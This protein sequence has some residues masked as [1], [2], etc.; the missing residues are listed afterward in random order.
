[1]C[2]ARMSRAPTRSGSPSRSLAAT[3]SRAAWHS[4]ISK[5][6][7]G[8]SSARDGSSSR[9]FARPM[10]WIRRAEPLGRG[11]RDHE[12]HRPPV[13]AEVQRGG[14]DHR[15]KLAPRHG[16]L[17][18][19]PLLHRK[20]AVVERDGK[21]VVVDLPEHLEGEFRLEAR[22]DEDERGL[23]GLD[24]VV[25]VGDGVLGRPPAPGRRAVGDQHVDHWGGAGRAQHQVGHPLPPVAGLGGQPAPQHVR[26]VHRR[27]QPHAPHGRREPLQPRER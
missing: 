6:W 14:A 16:G 10:R 11:E 13:D 12:V 27:R 4:S 23:G 9:W 21:V 2:W 5:R 3:A 17:D 22:I 24:G 15:A 1:M 18:A 26:V 20:R 25:D 7:A 8:T 19:A